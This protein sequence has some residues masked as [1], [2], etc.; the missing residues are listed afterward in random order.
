MD[1][2]QWER[3]KIR[4][5][6]KSM[7]IYSQEIKYWSGLPRKPFLILLKS[8]V[9]G[10]ESTSVRLLPED[11]IS[12]KQS[13]RQDTA[14]W[15][16]VQSAAL[17]GSLITSVCVPPLRGNTGKL[18]CQR[19]QNTKQGAKHCL[20]LHWAQMEGKRAGKG[21]RNMQNWKK[22]EWGSLGFLGHGQEGQLS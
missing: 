15:L 12:Y 21:T 11:H 22:E 3:K 9:R 6:N 17:F 4:M 20:Q 19:K 14:P 13:H 5:E 10:Y 16:A 7:L 2:Q 18:S 8:F 1:M